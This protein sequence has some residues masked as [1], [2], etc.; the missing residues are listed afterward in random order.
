MEAIKEQPL[1]PYGKIIN[2][3]EERNLRCPQKPEAEDGEKQKAK[4]I[5]MDKEVIKGFHRRELI[6]RFEA[7]FGI[8][9]MPLNI[10]SELKKTYLIEDEKIKLEKMTLL[11]QIMKEFFSWNEKD[12]EIFSK[13]ND[14]KPP[15]ADE[16]HF[17]RIESLYAKIKNNQ[18]LN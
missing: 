18:L 14:C 3:G 2:L 1:N 8:D 17:N 11:S 6:N 5:P 7:E 16:P 4:I 10:I 12:I 9:F 13:P 15:V